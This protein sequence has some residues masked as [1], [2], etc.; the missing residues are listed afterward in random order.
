MVLLKY[1]ITYGQPH[2]VQELPKDLQAYWTFTE[3]L[4]VEDGLILKAI[5]I[6]IPPSMKESM[7]QQLHDG[8]LDFTKCNNHARQTVLVKPQEETGRPNTQL[9]TVFEV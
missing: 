6:V 1:T 5:R 2:T 9:S 4:T 8:D 7:Q 3:E